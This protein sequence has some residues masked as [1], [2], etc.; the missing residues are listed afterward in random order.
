MPDA[1]DAPPLHPWHP[2]HGIRYAEVV[3]D[4]TLEPL[5][6]PIPERIFKP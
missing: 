2:V 5:L 1:M 6:E 4:S 3:A